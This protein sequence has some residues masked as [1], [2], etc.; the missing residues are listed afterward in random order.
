MYLVFSAFTSQPISLLAITKASVFFFIVCMLPSNVVT[1]LAIH[2]IRVL[3]KLYGNAARRYDVVRTK[4][5]C[6]LSSVSSVT[7]KRAT[8]RYRHSSIQR[9]AIL[10]FI[11]HHFGNTIRISAQTEPNPPPHQTISFSGYIQLPLSRCLP[12]SR[13]KSV[14]PSPLSP[15]PS[16]F[17][18]LSGVKTPYEFLVCSV[19]GSHFSH[20][21]FPVLVE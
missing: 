7:T 13:L 8:K 3:L 10:L 17:K 21:L 5:F 18:R 2:V 14:L 1:S 11:A 19:R 20:N 15:P 16:S 6:A 9:Y 12:V 4:T